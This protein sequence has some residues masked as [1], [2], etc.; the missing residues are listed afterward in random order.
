MK[1]T[2]LAAVG[3]LCLWHSPA[4][5]WPDMISADG[6]DS[7][8][9]Y[10]QLGSATWYA[11]PVASNFLVSKA[12]SSFLSGLPIYWYTNGS[13]VACGQGTVGNIYLIIGGAPQ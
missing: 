4:Q 11:M 12:M 7:T 1:K 10:V 5:A 9:Y 3:T 13:T 8:C 6:I 2:L